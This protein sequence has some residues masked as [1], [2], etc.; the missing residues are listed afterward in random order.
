[1][2]NATSH[3][4]QSNLLF[5]LSFSLPHLTSFPSLFYSCSTLATTF[6]VFCI[7]FSSS[8]S[9]VL[10][11]F[12]PLNSHTLQFSFAWTGASTTGAGNRATTTPRR[13]Y[14]LSS[15][16]GKWDSSTLVCS[17]PRQGNT[18]TTSPFFIN[19]THRASTVHITSHHIPH[20]KLCL[21]AVQQRD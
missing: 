3:R 17:N 2:T 20:H 16:R 14:S 13:K 19:D 9:P 21:V 15:T 12:T 5:F 10:T 4:T 8:S 6:A 18:T 1:M 11:P 7:P